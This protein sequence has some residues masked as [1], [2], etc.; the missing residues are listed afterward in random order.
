MIPRRL[1]VALTAML[2]GCAVGPRYHPAPVVPATTR[3][4]AGD[5]SDSARSFYDSL[6][7]ARAADS[8]GPPVAPLPSRSIAADSIADL[9]W[10]DILHDSTL[11]RLVA[12]ALRQNRDLALAEARIR[13]YRA[14]AGV[15]RGPLFPSLTL[16]GGAST[17]QI[18]LGAFPPASYEAWRVTGDV[19]WEL[20]FWGRIRR[21]IQAAGAD[22]S[23]QRAATQAAVLSLVSDVATGYLQLLELDQE[24]EIAERTSPVARRSTWRSSAMRVVSSPSWMCGS[25][26][27]RSRSRRCDWLR[28]SSCGPPRS[29]RSASCS[30]RARRPFRAA[31]RSQ[32]PR[33]PSWSPIRFRVARA[34]A[35]CAAG[36]ARVRGCHGADR[37]GG[38]GAA[39]DDHDHRVVRLAGVQPRQSVQGRGQDLSASRRDLAPA[40]HGGA[41]RQPGARGARACGASRRAVRADDADGAAGG[42][43][44]ARGVQATSDQGSGA[45]DPGPG[46][47]AR[48][49]ARRMRY[50]RGSRNYSRCSMRSA[51]CS[52]PSWP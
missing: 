35:R 30:A 1:A 51:A 9:A 44:R 28:W 6:A 5:R 14:L 18:V 21:G 33:A 40:V 45:G 47:A 2:A 48:A 29:T 39:A 26:R 46:V 52:T 16:N 43:R 10:L 49:G 22:L 34:A 13:E 27:R 15:A 50:Q 8:I 36:R 42:G 25:S 3:V 11:A 37:R 38:R 32:W 12:T 20:D 7:A 23:A 4:G 41:T 24:R 31:A 19:A 17:N